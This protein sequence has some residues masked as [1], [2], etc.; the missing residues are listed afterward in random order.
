M[1]TLTEFAAKYSTPEACLK[2]LEAVRWADGEFCPHCGGCGKIYH[3]KDGRRHKCKDCGKVFRIITGT[4]FSDSPINLL[5]KWF[6]AIYLDTCQSK[7]ISSVQLAKNIGV[8]QQTA[9]YMLQRIRHAAGAGETE[10]LGGDVEVDETYIGGKEKNKHISKRT[11]GTQGRSTKTKAV[12]F[13]MKERGGK[14][15]LVHVKGAKKSDIMP[16]VIKNVALGTTVYADELQSYS[17]LSGF[18]SLSRVN[19][20]Q[21]EYVRGSAHTNSIES[22][23]A[24]VKRVYVGI[25]HFWS[26][27]HTQRYLNSCT[28][29]LNHREDPVDA[30]LSALLDSGSSTRLTYNGLIA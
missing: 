22:V 14:V 21:G 28:F 1:M 17:S 20:G 27:K 6:M 30:R 24:L 12:A 13:G 3:Y 25:H 26:I 18:Y 2:R 19:H 8:K 11:K 4:I 15:I 29:R 9:W 23:W 7:G 10:V 5:P 16:H